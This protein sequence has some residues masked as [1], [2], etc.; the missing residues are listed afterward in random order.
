M[1]KLNRNIVESP[2]SLNHYDHQLHSWSDLDSECKK[3]LR[4][5]LVKMHGIP[6]VTTEDASEYGV[7]CAYCEG[8]I[9][10]EG[11]IE[12]FRRKNQ[13]HFPELTFE[14]T[15][16]FLSCGS[17]EHCGHY[18]DRPKGAGYNADC[19][20]KP[21]IHDPDTY[22][23]FHSSGQVEPRSGLGNTDR[24]KANETICVF[25][26][27][28]GTLPSERARAVKAYK[29]TVLN[30]LDEILSWEPELRADYIQNE[31][32]ETQWQPYSTTI[33]HFLSSNF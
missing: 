13:S 27:D 14:W 25:G 22:L 6:D 12:H 15:N 7:R 19:L 28:R 1:H 16:L 30:E 23:F 20:I 10:H 11:H 3:Q 5:A 31:I 8:S 21:D 2:A 24:Q 17:Q 18:K 33:K 4:A 9:H 29:D 32:E 26:L